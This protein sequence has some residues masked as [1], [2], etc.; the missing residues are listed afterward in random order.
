MQLLQ[1]LNIH[2]IYGKGVVRQHELMRRAQTVPLHWAFL[3]KTHTSDGANTA[4]YSRPFLGV[5]Y[6]K[7]QMKLSGK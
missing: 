2:K 5:P 4:T 1:A 3:Q 6:V 7:S